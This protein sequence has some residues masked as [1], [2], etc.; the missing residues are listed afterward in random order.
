MRSMGILPQ[1]LLGQPLPH[2]PLRVF[3]PVGP[4]PATARSCD[5]KRLITQLS[6]RVANVM[7]ILCAPDEGLAHR[8]NALPLR[9]FEAFAIATCE[10][11]NTEVD[12]R[13]VQSFER[14]QLTS[15]SH[16]AR[17]SVS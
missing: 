15:N 10:R 3:P 9:E 16:Q 6:G 11:A 13:K 12:S 2:P 5:Q 8:L 17:T 1:D 7:Q 14:S 4:R